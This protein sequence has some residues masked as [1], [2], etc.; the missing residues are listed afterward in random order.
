MVYESLHLDDLVLWARKLQTKLHTD[1]HM[2][3]VALLTS[4][5]LVPDPIRSRRPVP[6]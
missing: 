6:G 1:P 2:G 5:G 4:Q 3:P